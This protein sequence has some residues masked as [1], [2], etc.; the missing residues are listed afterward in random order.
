ML[1]GVLCAVLAL[2]AGAAPTDG[3]ADVAGARPLALATTPFVP[4][5]S[6][7]APCPE[8]ESRSETVYAETFDTIP[9]ERYNVGFA[10]SPGGTNG[11]NS[12]HSELIGAAADE[13]MFLPYQ[14]VPQGGRTMLG[15]A[16][17]GGGD[18][19]ARAAVNSV[20][21]SFPT[22]SQWTGVRVD[23]TEATNDEDGWLS[24]WFEHRGVS[25]TTSSLYID[26]A[27]I[28][29]CRDNRTTRIFGRDRYATAAAL[30]DSVAPGTPV[31][32]VATGQAFPDA[33]SAAA[34]AGSVGAPVVLVR[35]NSIPAV[36]AE[37]LR[38]L[39]PDTI[40]VVGGP[41]AVQDRVLTEL[42]AYASVV[43][44]VSGDDRYA[45]SAEIS[46][47]FDVGPSTA[48]VATGRNFPDA[49]SGGALAVDRG[50]PMLLVNTSSIP[51]S[52]AA[53]LERLRPARIV[54]FGGPGAVEDSVLTE[55]AGY[56]TSGSGSVRRI[57]GSDRY[58]VSANI[59]AEFAAPAGSYVATG[60]T[61]ADAIAGGVVAGASG[62]PLLLTRPNDLPNVVDL[63][64]RGIAESDGVVLGGTKSVFP[65][66][67]DQYG[68]TLP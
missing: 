34:L 39:D 4:S 49:L 57:G 48:F 44:R 65:I 1:V 42:G 55:L 35:S 52:I 58:E 21:T 45:T 46:S 8:G 24:T 43:E 37:A 14:H 66:V 20:L 23:I 62:A 56:A 51:G 40:V 64:L 26:Q 50:G 2:S 16:T 41:S 67:R 25:G 6:Y 9:E 13:Y 15:F 11:A 29:R 38:R 7:Q 30:T 59:A 33:L 60:T 47:A 61:F 27:E 22:S 54:V 53:E 17:R 18:T 5:P 12:A 32:Y 31:V 3:S 36:T 19:R 63:R 68:R 10:P 28:Y